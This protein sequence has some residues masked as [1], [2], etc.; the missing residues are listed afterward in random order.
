MDAGLLVNKGEGKLRQLSVVSDIHSRY[1]HLG[2]KLVAKL[3]SLMN[4]VTSRK[5][6]FPGSGAAI[7]GFSDEHTT[8]PTLENF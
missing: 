5:G 2:M 6:F 7:E 3:A 4:L 8:W 1:A